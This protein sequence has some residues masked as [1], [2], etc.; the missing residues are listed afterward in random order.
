MG[1]TEEAPE[2]ERS[3]LSELQLELNLQDQRWAG[4]G[5]GGE[6]KRDKVSLGSCPSG[7]L[8]QGRDRD[9]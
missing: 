1:W 2:G 4:H 7:I 5:G 6:G 9:P 3:K 8:P